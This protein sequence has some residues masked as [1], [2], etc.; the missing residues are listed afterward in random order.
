MHSLP[1][2]API[3]AHFTALAFE[4]RMRIIEFLSM[5]SLNVLN[6]SES[7]SVSILCFRSDIEHFLLI[8]KSDQEYDVDSKI[9]RVIKELQ[10]HY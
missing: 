8:R 6:C 4:F 5:K 9:E 2:I 1:V 3:R 10:V 7:G